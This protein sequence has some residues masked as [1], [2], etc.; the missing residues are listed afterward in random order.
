M[1]AFLINRNGNR[2]FYAT[3]KSIKGGKE[4]KMAFFVVIN[5]RD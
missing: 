5:F 2:H 3:N 1:R 4:L